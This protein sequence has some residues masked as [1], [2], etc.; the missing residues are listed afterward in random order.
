MLKNLTFAA[1][2]ALAQAMP[3]ENSENSV[4]NYAWSVT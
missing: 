4:S 3:T 2:M 1:A